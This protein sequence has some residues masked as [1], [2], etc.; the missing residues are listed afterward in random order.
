MR[1]AITR[2]PRAFLLPGAERWLAP[3]SAQAAAPRR[4]RVLRPLALRDPYL[5]YSAAVIP[6][7]AVVLAISRGPSSLVALGVLAVVFVGAQAILGQIPARLRP[8]TPL[9]WSFLRLA[10]A[11][12]LVAG[13]VELSGGAAGPLAAL[14]IPVVVA[15][16]ALGPIQALVIGGVASVI[17]LA[18]EVARIG[19]TAD[20]ALRG[21]TLAGVSILVAVGT[22][23]LVV[24]IERTSRK[25][26]SAMLAERRRSRQ[27][28]GMEAVSRLLMAGGPTHEVLDGALGLLVDR[29]GY[30][31]VSI[32]LHDG[33][34]LV[35]GAQR[36]YEHPIAE[37]DG[38]AGV[39][40]RVM[41]SH[42][43]AFV[44]D[45]SVDADYIGVFDEV[46][47]EV[48]APLMV[49]G[50][51]LGILNVES[52]EPLDRTDRDL[53]ATLAGRVAT[54]V[55]L[56]RDRQALAERAAVLR[57]LHEFTQ[58]IGAT[59]VVDRLG[60]TLVDAVRK[61]VPAD[62]V[63]LTV[64]DQATGRYYV[65]AI[66][67]VDPSVLGGEVRPGEGLA[68]RAI[69]D[70]AVVIDEDFK[71]QQFPASYRE[72]TGPMT[73]LGAGVP[74]V[75][76]GVVVG[77]L[78]IVRRDVTD[79][80]RPIEREAMD[81]L[82]GHAALALA[83]AFLHAAVEELAIRDPLT[84][85]YNRRYFD[86]TVERLIASWHRAEPAGRRAV[87]AILFDLDHFGDF[88]KRHGHHTGDLVL[89]TFAG[90]LRRRFRA[91]DLVARLGGEEFIVV[92]ED[93]TRADAQKIA[94]EVRTEL[95]SI[96]LANE[97]GH[98]LSVT[99]SAGCTQLEEAG[100]TRETLLRTADVAL[101]MAKRA[102]RDRVVAA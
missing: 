77:A 27:I 7:A 51:F 1:P 79:A 99:V 54:V 18:P 8:L 4:R 94:E 81:L 37:F 14:F 102:G 53:V 76:D 17:Y 35:L 13:V 36:G 62:F 85:L 57:S 68:G 42:Q 11:L 46:V 101:F 84:G 6:V 88:N 50:Q 48:C 71:T 26:R 30:R 43:I 33:T 3:R 25:L 60:A 9:G 2:S 44:P 47:S 40:G 82:A 12:L 80:F 70:R 32:Y 67:D 19:S 49:D 28:T 56:G 34:R 75:R 61:V 69:R 89:R 29:F 31:H 59:L 83:N 87:S 93:A 23:R 16:S 58:A 38:T 5:L 95:K 22:R 20:V 72:R 10:L 74:L 90:I 96:G 52:R 21:V 39:M 45:V 73:M 78:S 15:A 41:R 63:V 100:S 97:D 64:L 66:T 86:E 24:A 91:A 92:L 55:A 98:R 65:R